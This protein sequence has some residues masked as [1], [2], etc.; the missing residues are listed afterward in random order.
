MRYFIDTEFDDWKPWPQLI[1]IG[2]V[3]DD[4]REYYAEFAEYDRESAKPWVAEHVLP[5]LGPMEAAKPLSQIRLEVTAFFRTRPN[6]VWA[7]L[8]HYD[9]VLFHH[10][11][12]ENM[13]HVP[14]NVP[15]DWW[16]LRQWRHSLVE[17]P[18]SVSDPNEKHHA[19]LHARWAKAEYEL[20]AEFVAAIP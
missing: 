7:V 8:P 3:A 17:P 2:I 13:D 1:S 11:L 4:G 14:A 12:F 10:G 20:L 15:L 6:E 18:E 16:D 19:L 5:H 9:W